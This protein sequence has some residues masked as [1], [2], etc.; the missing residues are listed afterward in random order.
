MDNNK[1]IL[2]LIILQVFLKMETNNLQ[3]KKNK[4]NKKLIQI[5]KIIKV[6]YKI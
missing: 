4:F 3:P 2:Y 6:E 1:I 5:I